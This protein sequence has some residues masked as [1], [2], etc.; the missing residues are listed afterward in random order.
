MKRI[1]IGHLNKIFISFKRG[2]ITA[3]KDVNLRIEAGGFFVLLGPSGCG[4]STLL[5]II[6]GIETCD[7]GEITIGN[8][9]A[10]APQKKIFLSPKERDVAMVFQN[11]A[12]YPHLTVSANIA[13]PLKMSKVNKEEI[14]TRVEAIAKTLEITQLLE[15]KPAELS[16]GQRQRVALGRAL[17]RR[18]GVLLLDEPLSNLDVLL[19]VS[20][21]S[22]L[23]KL[24]KRLGVTTVYVTHD[25][26]E[27]LSLGDQVAVMKDGKIMQVGTPGEI[28][29]YPANVFVAMFVGHP[30]MN[31]WDGT[32][33][34][35]L[36]NKMPVPEK[37]A[38]NNLIAGLRPEHIRLT[39][40][41]KGLLRGEISLVSPM[42][43]EVLIHVSVE[44]F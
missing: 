4:K 26:T 22:E 33:L 36:K 20:M 31:Q 32:I 27:A 29:H 19:R 6:A 23:K 34:E 43:S 41:G 37:M 42:G 2:K 7:S 5:N 40:P 18:P 15:V 16:G 9:L 14:I 21:R 11:Y 24:Q 35:K 28:Y 38:L 12:L 25:Q 3:I 13:F 8:Q 39:E 1:D 10:V 17:V 44:H 30:P